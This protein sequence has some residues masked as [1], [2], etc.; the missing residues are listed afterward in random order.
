MACDVGQ[1]DAFVLR[2][3]PGA[4][5]VVDAGPDPAA[6]DGC[7]TRLGVEDVPLMI[8]SHLHADHIGGLAGVLRG[9]RVG[10][11]GLGPFAEPAAGRARVEQAAG[12]AGV[13]VAALTVGQQYQLGDTRLRVLAPSTV[14]RGTRSDPNNNSLVLR[15]EVVG[16]SILLAGDVEQE[17]ERALLDSGEVLAADVLKVPHH[18]SAQCERQFLDAVDPRVALVGVGARND[19][20]H[21]NPGVL[22]HLRRG[23]ARVLRT[24]RDGDIAVLLDRHGLA[25]AVAGRTATSPAG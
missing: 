25:T 16:V 3:G 18:G 17:A 1:G 14:F 20:G 21:P 5:V 13:P 4:A 11:I 24:D 15:A 23:G 8:A 7:L 19:Y 2:A 12:A 10:A 6:V 22:D 9:R